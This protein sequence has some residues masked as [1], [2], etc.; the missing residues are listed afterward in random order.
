MLTLYLFYE[1]LTLVTLPLVMHN[2]D[3]KT[4]YAGRIYLIYMMGGASLAFIGLV[5][6]VIYGNS[7]DF[8][9]GG[10]LNTEL[11]AKD[12][13]MLHIVYLLACITPCGGSRKSR[14]FCNYSLDIL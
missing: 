13:E 6:L 9:M 4:R 11:A 10:I 3:G 1:F 14:C 5:F 12:E 2:S 7:L 8:V